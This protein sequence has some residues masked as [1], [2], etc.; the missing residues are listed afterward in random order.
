QTGLDLIDWPS[1]CWFE[2]EY[3]VYVMRQ[4]S[5]RSWRIGQR[6]AVEVSHLVYG[7]TLQAEALSLASSKMRSSLMIEGEL[8]EDGLA[9]LA[10]NDQDLMLT[11]AR[12]LADQSEGT[13]GSLEALFAR[14]SEADAE[15]ARYLSHDNWEEQ[16]LVPIFGPE[17]GTSP[18][19]AIPVYSAPSSSGESINEFAQSSTTQQ[20]SFEELAGLVRKPRSRKRTI[21]AEQLKLFGV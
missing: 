21:P 1:I 16:D 11:L 3:S 2:T 14:R 7:G 6:Q 19:P 8:P 9:A 15:S 4:A 5:R 12:R 20:I 13:A 17:D 10:G 18:E